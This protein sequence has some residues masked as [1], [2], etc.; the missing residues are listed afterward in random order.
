MQSEI[1]E[2]VG[3]QSYKDYTQALNKCLIPYFGGT[4]IAKI[5]LLSPGLMRGVRHRVARC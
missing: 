3:K 4:D 5:W 2:G 1:R